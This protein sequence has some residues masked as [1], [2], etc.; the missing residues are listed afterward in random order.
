M[1]LHKKRY[2]IFVSGLFLILALAGCSL[3]GVL[4]NASGRYSDI[5]GYNTTRNEDIAF[6][7]KHE[8]TITS[9]NEAHNWD[10]EG[11]A[12][13]T[14]TISVFGFDSCDPRIKLIN[15]DGIVLAEDDDGGGGSNSLIIYDLPLEGKYTVRIDALTEGTYEISLQ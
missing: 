11:A 6:G 12:G 7:E 1:N 15:P 2:I 13:Q 4:G 5:D 8:G 14:V 9:L 10:F 3:A